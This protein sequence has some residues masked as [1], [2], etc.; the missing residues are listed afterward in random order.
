VATLGPATALCGRVPAPKQR[1]SRRRD[2]I[3]RIDRDRSRMFGMAAR[4]HEPLILLY[5]RGS[6]RFARMCS[7]RV[8][9]EPRESLGAELPDSQTQKQR[10][11]VP[12]FPRTVRL[13]PTVPHRILVAT[14]HTAHE[15]PES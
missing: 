6:R 9:I 5:E 10:S 15:E 3:R 12:S 4:R 14:R 11:D 8:T 1:D 13:P 7:Q 2:R